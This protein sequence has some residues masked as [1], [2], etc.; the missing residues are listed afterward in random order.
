MAAITHKRS[1][2]PNKAPQV[3]DLL[4]GEL[5][6]NTHDGRLFIK[7]TVGGVAAVTTF[8]NQQYYTDNKATYTGQNGIMLELVGNAVTI[9]N[10]QDL[11]SS[12]SPAFSNLTVSNTTVATTTDTG[13][14]TVTGGVGI[15]GALYIGDG[16]TVTKNS[17]VWDFNSDGNIV[18]PVNG[19]IFNSDGSAIGSSDS[20]GLT[21]TPIKTTNYT[22]VVNDLVRCNSTAG[23]FS[24]TLPAL[25]EDGAVVSVIDVYSTFSTHVV[26]VI[27]DILHTLEQN[28]SGIELDVTGTYISF[29]YIAATLNWRVLETPYLHAD[30]TSLLPTS[31]I[32]SN[33]TAASYDLIRC[34][35]VNG[36]F[37][38][39]FP[40]VPMDGSSIGIIDTNNTFSD[41][42]VVLIASAGY[43]IEDMT[44]YP[45]STS[46]MWVSFIYIQATSN[47]RL[48]S[49]PSVSG[50]SGGTSNTEIPSQSGLA[51]N[52]LKTNGST[53]SWAGS[54]GTGAVVLTTSP[55]LIT[56]ILGIP[57]SGALQNCTGYLYSRLSG[58]VT[59]WNQNTA[60]TAATASKLYTSRSISITGDAA[61]TVMFDGSLNA[62]SNITLANV[63]T[64]GTSSKITF[65][66]K[67]LVTGSSPLSVADISDIATTYQSN[68]TFL[69]SIS[70]LPVASG[71]LKLTNGIASIDATVYAVVNDAL[72]TPSSGNLVNC[73]GYLHSA[74][75]GEIP[76][77]NQNTTGT[78]A[79]LTTTLLVE[80]GGTGVQTLTGLIKGNGTSAFSAAVAGTDY[81][82]PIG[83][84]NGM[85]KGNGA[86]AITAAVAGTDYQLPIGTVNGIV[87][88]NGFN[89]IITAV[90]GTDYQL[91]IG[92]VN[93][94]VK[95]NGTNAIIAAVAG[96]DYVAPNTTT[97]FTAKQ[98]FNGS[99]TAL[100]AVFSNIVESATINTTA[101]TGTVNYD[102]ALQ[103]VIFNT[104]TATGN[105]TI[106]FRHSDI[107]PLNS[108]LSIGQSLTV[109]F[110]ASIGTTGYYN[111]AL[112]IDEVAI[113][114]KW[115]NGVAPTI[116]SLNAVD[117]YT[118]T[119]IKTANATFTVFASATKFG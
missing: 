102:T 47:W 74:L 3:S 42:P 68:S 119:I 89:S 66:S 110:L 98:L 111:I 76:V 107:T 1:A 73:T 117:I 2:V 105:W 37:S 45:L 82:R 69:S 12:A 88:G 33:T 101:L 49:S 106:N 64:A 23:V 112:Q 44:S 57:T 84:I 115:Q 118:Y 108:V 51:G 109:A 67:G 31:I 14:L 50:G 17:H 81:Q 13:A 4:D 99:T 36:G 58:P 72:G 19:G 92:T 114:P 7:T 75:V 9:K 71:V 48:L 53:L 52:F 18:L 54:S 46:G 79:G 26:T 56:P 27:P 87:K 96:T 83:T 38:I 15:G 61:W 41:H 97:T 8:N 22:A 35:S 20:G 86:N 34:N 30:S 59:I 85:V 116:G 60:G 70:T 40:A 77:W 21:P 63:V 113:I 16:L 43:T 93:G 6:I 100:S 90:A 25:P 10:S 5:S 62:S 65:N 29:T 80:S 28:S 95:G 24:I 91:P 78:A 39:Y 11:T 104:A 32:S 103:S 94:I 55:S